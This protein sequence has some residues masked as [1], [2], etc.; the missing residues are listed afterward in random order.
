MLLKGFWIY[1]LFILPILCQCVQV[2]IASI[3]P[4]NDRRI[5]S[6]KRVS[7]A[8]EYAIESLHKDN[9]LLKGHTLKLDF[10]DSKCSIAEA[11]N[12]AIGFYIKKQVDVFFGPVCDFSLA[13]VARQAKFW[14]I[15]LV[16]VGAMARDFTIHRRSLYPL[17][18]RVGPVNFDSLSSF[19]HL[20]LKN[21][22]LRK[23]KM[24]YERDGQDHIV[25][26]FCHLAISALH[27]DLLA[28]APDI[29]Q[30]YYK[31]TEDISKMLEE[32]I[33]L[34]FSG[35]FHLRCCIFQ[36]QIGKPIYV[37]C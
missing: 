36:L 8:I 21:F 33:A 12:Q 7:P 11:M 16:S 35:K 1:F 13:P 31:L 9:G 32:E 4:S 17:L 29:K 10:E 27:Y 2:Q 19:F 25:D 14:N 23:F 28:K 37:V 34:S 26:G 3:L 30:D 15:P 20:A 6:I 24:V 22:N 5:F 18:T